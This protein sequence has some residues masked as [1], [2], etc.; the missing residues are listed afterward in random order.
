MSRPTYYYAIKNFGINQLNQGKY[1]LKHH[2]L[3]T[4][5]KEILT[6][7]YNHFEPIQFDDVSIRSCI[8]VSE[9]GTYSRVAIFN[10]LAI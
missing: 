4:D 6:T 2:L 1:S 7:K 5:K 9:C 8:T 10:M 3:L